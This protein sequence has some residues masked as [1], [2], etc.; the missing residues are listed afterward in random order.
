M[1]EWFIG[2]SAIM[3]NRINFENTFVLHTRPFRDTSL[4]V[5]AFTANHGHM[6]MLARGARG[7]KSQLRSVLVPFTPLLVSWAQK[8]ELP[9][10]N[11]VEASNL[12]YNLTGDAIMN[13]MYLNE[14]LTRL[15]PRY[16]AYP[17]LFHLYEQTLLTMQDKSK[18]VPAVRFFEKQLLKELGYELVLDKEVDGTPV[19]PQYCYYFEFGTG[20]KKINILT[21]TQPLANVFSGKSLLALQNNHLDGAQQLSDAERILQLSLK[22]I[23]GN[24]SIKSWKLL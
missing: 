9:I 16:D 23:L 11:K 2:G 20:L 14:L 17:E 24:Q 5:N 7:P 8:T 10:V 21:D 22:H 12:Q 13:G 18:I 19:L 3:V 15:L 1:W 4:L 6:P